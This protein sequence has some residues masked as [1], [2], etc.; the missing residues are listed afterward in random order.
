MTVFSV[1]KH[2]RASS[3]GLYCFCLLLYIS[4][5]QNVGLTDVFKSIY[6]CAP[7]RKG[8]LQGLVLSPLLLLLCIDDLRRFVPENMEVVMFADDVSLFSNHPNKKIVEAGT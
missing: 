4:F 7:Q 3:R 8:F 6:P 2:L 5:H 1:H